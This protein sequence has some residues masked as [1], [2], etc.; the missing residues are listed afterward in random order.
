MGARQ[1]RQSNRPEY[2]PLCS[3]RLTARF[4]ATSHYKAHTR[5]GELEQ[6]GELNLWRIPNPKNRLHDAWWSRGFHVYAGIMLTPEKI[7]SE[8]RGYLVDRWQREH[9]AGGYPGVR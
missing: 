5:R 8:R 4:A 1:R 2:C 6:K 3:Q 7:E 9:R